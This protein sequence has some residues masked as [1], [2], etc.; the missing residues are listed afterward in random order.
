MLFTVKLYFFTNFSI[1]WN[2]KF[3]HASSNQIFLATISVKLN[4]NLN[5]TII[6]SKNWLWMTSFYMIPSYSQ[7]H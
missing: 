7:D 1:I 3:V 6:L 4:E 5:I 2:W